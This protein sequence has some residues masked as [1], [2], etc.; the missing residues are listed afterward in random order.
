M[1]HEQKR[2]ERLEDMCNRRDDQVTQLRS[3]F[4]QSLNT[5][6]K[7]TKNIKS[8]LGKSLKKLD[9]EIKGKEEITSP[10]CSEFTEDTTTDIEYAP[11]TRLSGSRYL[12]LPTSSQNRSSK[13]ADV[14]ASAEDRYWH[15]GK[16][17]VTPTPKSYS[18][19]SSDRKST[20]L[21]IPSNKPYVNSHEVPVRDS[22]SYV[23]DRK[24][25]KRST[26]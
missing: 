23:N 8:I 14:V 7:D 2:R 15:K 17:I 24:A 11:T 20:P 21:L 10:S 18:H 16:P 19:R 26:R 12:N 13:S 6:S 4:D 9:H 3:T 25:S 5:L 1:N 22:S